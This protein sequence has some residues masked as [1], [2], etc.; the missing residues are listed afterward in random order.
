M[1]CADNTGAKALFV[2]GVKC[3]RGRLNKLPAASI[4]DMII[5]SCKKGKPELRKKGM[6]CW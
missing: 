1:N 6:P 2:I 4:G 5:A 3:V